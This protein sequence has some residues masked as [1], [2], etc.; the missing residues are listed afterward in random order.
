MDYTVKRRET[1]KSDKHLTLMQNVQNKRS[2]R[3]NVVLGSEH[4]VPYKHAKENLAFDYNTEILK[5]NTELCQK[6]IYFG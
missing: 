5:N 3:K 1:F 6:Y 2:Q 4:L